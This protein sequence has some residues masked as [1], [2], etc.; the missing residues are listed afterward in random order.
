MG[1]QVKKAT[2]IGAGIMGAQI[3][4][5]LTNNNIDVLLL[6]RI[7]DKLSERDMEKG[8][9]KQSPQWRNKIAQMGIDGLLKL[10]HPAFISEESYHRVT[11]G[12]VDDDLPQI[13]DSDWIIETIIEDL[14]IKRALYDKIEPLRR[15]DAIVSTN[16]SGLPISLI[17]EEF[18]PALKQYFLGTHFFNPPTYSPL[19]ELIPSK[20][21]L[22]EVTHFLKTIFQDDMGK[23]PLV[24]K[25]TPNFIANRLGIATAI[26]A[27][28]MA[29]SDGMRVDE[30]DALA[31]RNMA[32]MSYAIF[33]MADAVGLDTVA[34]VTKNLYANAKHDERRESFFIPEPMAYM[35]ENNMLGAKSRQGFYYSE[36]QED[37]SRKEYVLDLNT[38]Q[39]IDRIE[40]DFACL[41]AASQVRSPGEKVR[42]II[43][44]DDRGAKFAWKMLAIDT[45]YAANRIG[46]IADTIVEIDG[47][48]RTGYLWALGPFE[49]WDAMG[50]R[51]S[52]ERMQAEGMPVPPSV[53]KMLETGHE[54]FYR[55]FEGKKQYYDFRTGSY[56]NV[57]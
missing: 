12:N 25:D 38:K 27:V 36:K 41:K 48:M 2:V 6:D 7:P 29:F 16:T 33:G 31:G 10:K 35:L 24:V 43:Y 32:R 28:H 45:I 4:A 8:W 37:G 54:S 40:P 19:V 50:L 42:A 56:Q 52:V 30:V 20:D 26:N 53:I 15:A 51:K 46:E 44:G 21:T 14:E 55:E 5:L 34:H 1:F 49:C 22:T 3:A 9:T 17:A 11:P 39:Y 23:K 47:A 18:S 13:A 57:E